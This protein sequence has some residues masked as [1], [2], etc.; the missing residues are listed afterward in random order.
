MVWSGIGG[1]RCTLLCNHVGGC[2]CKHG[3]EFVGVV[4]D[5]FLL[6]VQTGEQAHGVDDGSSIVFNLL[7]Q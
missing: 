5:K 1:C 6:I 7:F 3:H 2:G 4:Y